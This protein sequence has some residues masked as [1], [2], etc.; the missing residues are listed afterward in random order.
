MK[1]IDSNWGCMEIAIYQVGLV[2]QGGEAPYGG[3]CAPAVPGIDPPPDAKDGDGAM[4]GAPMAG[5]G[6]PP[7]F[8]PGVK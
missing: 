2:T 4:V 3:S 6:V 7:G 1:R 8:D 5:A